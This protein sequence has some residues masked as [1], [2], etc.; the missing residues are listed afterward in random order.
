MPP[1]PVSPA[2]ADLDE[3]IRRLSVMEQ[4]IDWIAHRVARPAEAEHEAPARPVGPHAKPDARSTARQAYA[5]ALAPGAQTP[6]P[7]APAAARPVPAT[8]GTGAPAGRPT[9]SG[10]EWWE[11]ARRE[12]NVG[13]YLLSGAAALLV[14]LAAV[15]LLAL[16]WSSIPDVVK[17]GSLELVAI[18]LVV[19]GTVL[20]S[21]RPGQRVAAATLTGTGGALGYV[22]VIGAVL[23]PLGVPVLAAFVLLAVWGAILL[24]IAQRSEQVLTAAISSVGAMVTSGFA[25]WF[26]DARGGDA[27]G[28]WAAV[29]VY[30]VV[31]AVL[32]GV[33]SRR[34]GD[35]RSD[36]APVLASVAATWFTALIVP[37]H[38][39]RAEP[40]WLGLLLALLPVVLVHAQVLEAAPALRTR[41]IA[42]AGVLD[43]VLS[44][45]ALL[46]VLVRAVGAGHDPLIVL[47]AG[48]MLLLAVGAVLLLPRGTAELR[49]SA[50]LTALVVTGLIG[51]C[52]TAIEPRLVLLA[53]AALVPT[54]LGLARLGSSVG[55]L[56]GPLW[57]AGLLLTPH[58]STT[59]D[60]LVLVTSLLSLPLGVVTERS[61]E[62]I[63]DEP[64]PVRPGGRPPASGDGVGAVPATVGATPG[65]LRTGT[66]TA[67]AWLTAVT[68]ALTVPVSLTVMLDRAGVLGDGDAT[69]LT[70]LLISLATA[71]VLALGL[72][73][74][75]ASPAALLS[76]AIAGTR[77]GVG[78]VDGRA[79]ASP[80]V[81]AAGIIAALLLGVLAL[82]DLSVA[83]AGDDLVWS[84]LLIVAAAGLM[85]LAARF[86][87]PWARESAVTLG[88]AGLAS[89]VL[90]WS[91]SLLT[92][93]SLT[94]VLLTIVI[95][96]TGAVCVIGGFR[97]RA[98]ML[99]HYGLSL[100][101]LAVLKL[102]LLD[103]GTQSSITRVVALLVAGLICFALSLAYNK[104]AGELGEPESPQRPGAPGAPGA[105]S[106]PT[107]GA[108]R[109]V[110]GDGYQ[111]P[112]TPEAPPSW[113]PQGARPAQGDECF[114]PPSR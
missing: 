3:V 85:A 94:S 110:P 2:T 57:G 19:G 74:R 109:P 66:L 108:P 37:T 68:V 23:L 65:A 33:L 101:L 29:V 100:V 26:S 48:L 47:A 112:L 87:L 81:P 30:L 53:L 44:G 34:S 76:G 45:L 50:S 58:V 32:G 61:L 102:A 73:A 6:R 82:T 46:M 111:A 89:I 67:A 59:G 15:T 31:L 95:L 9:A 91:V 8:A 36:G 104:A 99:H 84:A 92:G 83:E 72:L 16:V 78:V 5:A 60:V 105:L 40:G 20:S 41:G 77:P 17:V 13:R 71:G 86:L 35:R 106:A 11:R 98:T 79:M 55:V 96:L 88:L 56:V 69:P 22:A 52:A 24:V 63:P 27:V 103:V 114:R 49:R 97:V 54:A 42:F 43:L 62:P 28:T 93:Q 70:V 14:L 21:R 12:G 51:L 107:P 80:Q 38:V 113:Q 39:L 18:G 90:W 4:K 1:N 7:A 64:T 75:G 10:P 25:S